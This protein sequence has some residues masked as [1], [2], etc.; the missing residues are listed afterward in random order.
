MNPSEAQEACDLCFTVNRGC[1]A[2]WALRC[3]ELPTFSTPCCQGAGVEGWEWE[4]PASYV[5]V[6]GRAPALHPEIFSEPC[7]ARDGTGLN[8]MPDK[9]NALL[10][11]LSPKWKLFRIENCD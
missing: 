1:V 10:I 11:L 9:L 2:A 7:C 5:A 4:A 3:Q 6:L 8:Y